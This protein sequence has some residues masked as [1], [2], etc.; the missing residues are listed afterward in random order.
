[1]RIDSPELKYIAV[2]LLVVVALIGALRLTRSDVARCR[3]VFQDLARGKRSVQQRIDWGQLHAIGVNVGATYAGLPDEGARVT[4]RRLF[5]E[6][7]SKGFLQTGARL[8][9]FVRWRVH[10]RTP[11]QVVVAADY[12]AKQKTL[13]LTMAV[14]GKKLEGIQWQ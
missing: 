14:S 13:L 7:F 9:E 10:E 4:Y 11:E 5:V 6:H 2:T 1:M 3:E 8:D 12:P